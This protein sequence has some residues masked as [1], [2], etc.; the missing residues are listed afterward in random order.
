VANALL[1]LDYIGNRSII[2]RQFDDAPNV[3][4]AKL[5]LR[6]T[7]LDDAVPCFGTIGL[8]FHKK[9]P[10]LEQLREA[11]GTPLSP[12]EMQSQRAARTHTIPVC[13]E[14]GGDLSAAAAKLGLSE[15]RLVELHCARSYQCAAV[16][17]VPGFAYL[18]ELEPAIS[19]LA[20]LPSPR[21]RVDSGSVAI[22]GEQT[23]VYP[24]ATP[25]GWWIIG[26]TPLS[27]VNEQDDYFPIAVGDKITFEP[28]D[29]NTYRCW[30]G[31][32][33]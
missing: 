21:S 7:G 28:I 6:L 8:Y 2:L 13:Y 30:E 14:L 5:R 27:L 29:V 4:A 9:V 12:F 17:F 24:L 22:A 16:G 3:A 1:K 20:R 23:A 25:G 31:Q 18:G 10:D 26:R 15:D 32:R 11:L 19:H 33:L